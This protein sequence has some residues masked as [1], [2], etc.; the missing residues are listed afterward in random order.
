MI[1][2]GSS[3]ASFESSTSLPESFTP[4][5]AYNAILIQ[6]NVHLLDTDSKKRFWRTNFASRGWPLHI[7]SY[8]SAMR[9]KVY[10]SVSL[11]L[12]LYI[13]NCAAECENACSGHGRC[14]AFDMCLCDR[15]WQANDCGDSKLLLQRL[16]WILVMFFSLVVLWWF[17]LCCRDV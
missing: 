15:N 12:V 17:D 9:P 11:I 10:L 1:N 13:L 14:T 3:S 8:L 2:A 7:K 5:Y 4:I 6:L 16:M